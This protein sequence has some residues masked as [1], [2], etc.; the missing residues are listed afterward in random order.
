MP[1]EFHQLLILFF[2]W[3]AGVLR[4]ASAIAHIRNLK[5]DFNGH[6]EVPEAK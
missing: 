3:V 1:S 5:E 2:A 6:F 4:G